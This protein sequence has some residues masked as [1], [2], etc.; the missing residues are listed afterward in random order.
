MMLSIGLFMII[1][2]LS[3]GVY[4]GNQLLKEMENEAKQQTQ[5]K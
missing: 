5:E 4:K 3:I 1:V 2:L